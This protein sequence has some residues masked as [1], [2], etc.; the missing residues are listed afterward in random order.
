MRF[1][2]LARSALQRLAAPGTWGAVLAFQAA[3]I[4]TRRLSGVPQTWIGAWE[5]FVPALFLSGHI[6]LD[7]LP[8]QWSGDDRPAVPLWR[9]LL[10]A[11][12]WNGAWVLLLILAVQGVVHPPRPERRGLQAAEARPQPPP[13]PR[14]EVGLLYLNLPFALVLGWFLAGKEGAESQGRELRLKER[15]ARALALQAQLHPHAL[16]NVLGGLAELV[17]E[18][19]EATE[20][21]LEDLAGMLRMLTRQGYAPTLPLARERELLRRYLAIESIR[22]GDRLTV[23]WDWPEWADAQELPP[24]LLQPLVEN[25]VKHGISPHPTGGLVEIGVAR[26][27]RELVLRVANGGAPLGTHP[28]NGTGLANLRERLELL[29]GMEGRFSLAAVGG[30]T[31]AEI[32]LTPMLG[33]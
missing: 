25:A 14:H 20:K 2:P 15:Q 1:A 23:R 7:A 26:E 17:R 8:W 33:A 13:G 6:L 3:W 11:L 10:Q 32:R 4:L 21:A 19:P 24:L 27:G 12:A 9:G 18:D 30:L 5:W 16:Y 29:P 31:L 28:G 22:L